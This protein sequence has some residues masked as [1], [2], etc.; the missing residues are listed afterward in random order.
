MAV[1]NSTQ[2][3]LNLYEVC[4]ILYDMISSDFRLDSLL[5]TP[6]KCVPDRARFKH[7]EKVEP[8]VTSSFLLLVAMACNLIAMASTE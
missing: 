2:V 5:G 7:A 4:A 1:Y 8:F 6:T 3:L